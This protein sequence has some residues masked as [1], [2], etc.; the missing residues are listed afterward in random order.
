MCAAARGGYGVPD[1]RSRQEF[2]LLSDV[3]GV[4]ALVDALNKLPEEPEDTG[5]SGESD[6][7][8]VPPQDPSTKAL[9]REVGEWL[10][11]YIE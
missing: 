4:S 11:T 8:P 3:L 6:A 2:I 9:A 10:E 1:A 5:P 7:P